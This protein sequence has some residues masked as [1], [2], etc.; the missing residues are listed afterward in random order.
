VRLLLSCSYLLNY[1]EFDELS[2]EDA[3]KNNELVSWLVCWTCIKTGGLPEILK[4]F[5]SFYS[6]FCLFFN[7]GIQN[8]RG[9]AEGS[10]PFGC[11]G[12]G[13]DESC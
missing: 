12:P 4:K 9:E 13:I 11:A 1:S 10:R 2:K 5:G 6:N 7:S 3:L 8:R